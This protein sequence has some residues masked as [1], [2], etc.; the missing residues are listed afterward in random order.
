M[1]IESIDAGTYFTEATEIAVNQS[2]V[3]LAVIG[4]KWLSGGAPDATNRLHD[5]DDYV[6]WELSTAVSNRN[7]IIPV[8][9]DGAEM[10]EGKLLPDEINSLHQCQT[11]NN[12]NHAQFDSDYDALRGKLMA[13]QTT[14]SD[15]KPRGFYPAPA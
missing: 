3:L 2:D 13:W 15:I 1:D 14:A 12:L 6:R 7:L 11:L 9:I 8:L 5:H 4:D 10:P